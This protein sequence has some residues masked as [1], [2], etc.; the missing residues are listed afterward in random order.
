V[1]AY[2][3]VIWHCKTARE[4]GKTGRRQSK[5]EQRKI[6]RAGCSAKDWWAWRRLDMCVQ[7]YRVREAG[8]TAR[9]DKKKEQ[10]RQRARQSETKTE[11]DCNCESCCVDD[12]ACW[13][14]VSICSWLL[15]NDRADVTLAIETTVPVRYVGMWVVQWLSVVSGLVKSVKVMVVVWIGTIPVVITAWDKRLKDWARVWGTREKKGGQQQ[16]LQKRRTNTKPK[17]QPTKRPDAVLDCSSCSLVAFD[18]KNTAIGSSDLEL[19]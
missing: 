4:H 14:Q 16:K 5:A 9:R 3:Y 7:W 19:G 10:R 2:S 6:Q 8:S 12:C 18:V 17:T 13:C 11:R 15:M 1:F